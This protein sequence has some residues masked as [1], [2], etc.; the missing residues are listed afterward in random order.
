MA[1]FWSRSIGGSS[2]DAQNVSGAVG[3]IERMDV[4]W[5]CR[6]RFPPACES[7]RLMPTIG[8]AIAQ[9]IHQSGFE[10][11]R[12]LI[13]Q[14]AH[15]GRRHRRQWLGAE[16]HQPQARA[17]P[18]VGI[19][20]LRFSKRRDRRFALAEPFA[21]VCERE[22]GRG[23]AGRKFGR[24]QQRSAAATRSPLSC[25]SRAKSNRRSAIRSPEDRNKRTGVVRIDYGSK[26]RLAARPGGRRLE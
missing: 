20:H 19:R 18:V 10:F 12:V 13:E 24:L 15:I 8:A 17:M 23:K 25:R 3:T 22:P 6:S 9:I 21:N 2:Q 16:Q 11:R 26:G 14:R 7:Q 5:I 4:R 1:F